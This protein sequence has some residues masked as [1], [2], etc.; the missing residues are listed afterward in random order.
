[1]IGNVSY[2]FEL[3]QELAAIHSVFHI[4]MLKKFM[5]DHSFIKQ[6]ED[7]GIKDSLSY[8]EIF[9][10][11]L[12]RKPFK[13]RTKEVALV[14]VHWRNH[15]VEEATLEAEEDMKKIY[16]YLFET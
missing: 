14:K 12:N 7:T 9:V 8:E 5:C 11:I 1:M 10:Q 15:F 2:E 4:Y 3:P 16:P 13:L 6:T